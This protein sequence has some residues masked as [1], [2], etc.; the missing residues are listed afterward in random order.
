[1]HSLLLLLLFLIPE[2][3]SFKIGLIVNIT[4][5]SYDNNISTIN[6]NGSC[7]SCSCYVYENNYSSFNC[8]TNNNTCIM[9]KTSPS[10]YQLNQTQYGNFYFLQL[11]SNGKINN[12]GEKNIF[13]KFV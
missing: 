11:P 7:L 13:L 12:K 5:I 3:K 2:T 6:F 9:F 8:F 1:M 10:I 4:L